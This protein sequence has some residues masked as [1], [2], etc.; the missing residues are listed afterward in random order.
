MNHYTVRYEYGGA[1]YQTVVSAKSEAD[2]LRQ[3]RRDAGPGVANPRIIS[4]QSELFSGE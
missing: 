3:F 2:A 4:N 1:T